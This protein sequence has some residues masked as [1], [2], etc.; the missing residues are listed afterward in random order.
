MLS[1]PPWKSRVAWMFDQ[2]REQVAGVSGTLPAEGGAQ[3]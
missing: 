1:P 2:V 3:L